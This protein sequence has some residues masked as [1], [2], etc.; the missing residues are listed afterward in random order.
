MNQFTKGQKYHT[1]ATKQKISKANSGEKNPNWKGGI[2]ATWQCRRVARTIAELVLKHPLAKEEVVHHIDG[3]PSNNKRVNL[4]ICT[5]E[6]HMTL[7]WNI[8]RQ[9][10]AKARLLQ[11]LST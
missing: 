6:E 2:S 8:R 9:Q 3:D 5:R 10:D 7:H 4:L 11:R 1:E